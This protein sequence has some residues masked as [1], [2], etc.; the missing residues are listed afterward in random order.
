[1]SSLA[2]IRLTPEQQ[3]AVNLRG[4]S[5]LV[6][7]AAG[8]GKTRV[9]VERL[10]AYVTDPDNP[11]DI[12]TFL[13][14]TYTRAA[15][16]ELHSRILS[17]LRKRSAAQPE[18]RRL[19]RQTDLCHRA[20]IGTIH[21]FC[22]TVLRENCHLLGLAPDFTVA[23]E[24]RSESIRH[25]ALERL[26]EQRYE[27]IDTDAGFRA[28]VDT[29]GAGRS[30]DRLIQVVDDLYQKLQSHPYP[31]EWANAQIQ[32]MDV[33]ACSD[34]AETIWGRTLLEELRRDIAYWAELYDRL[35]AE[36]YGDPDNEKIVAAY[37]E[38]L[39]EDAEQLR[40]IC[41]AAEQG[42]ELTRTQFPFS[43]GKLKALRN[44]PNPALSD[45]I[46]ACR[47]TLKSRAE[48]WAAYFDGTSEE[49]L[50]DLTAT[51]PAMEALLRLTLDLTDAFSKE[52]RR[53]NI[54]DFS[55]LEHFAIQ[56]LVHQEDRSPT[57]LAQHI[58]QRYTEIMID[59]FQDV[60]EVQDLLFRAVSRNE[61]NLFMVGDVKQSIYRFRLAD[62][63]IFIRKYNTY[64][65]YAEAEGSAPRRILLRENFR[66]QPTVLDSTNLVFDNIMSTELGDI[67]YDDNARLRCGTTLLRE[68][69]APTMLYLLPSPAS[70]DSDSP[71][72][73]RQEADFIA[74]QIQAMLANG[75]TVLDKD[76][77][78]R[79]MTYGDIVILMRSPGSY[80][81]I[82]H[83]AL[84]A[85]G[86]PVS[87]D[88]SG[89]FFTAPEISTML[90]LLSIVD[91]PHQDVPLTS[92]LRSPIFGF[93]PDELSQI[94]TCNR[95]SDF[96]TALREAAATMPK[97]QAFLET[98]QGFRDRAADLPVDQMIWHIYTETHLMALCSAMPD[99]ALRRQKLMILFRY[100]GQFESGGS[101]GLFL[102]LAWINR[103]IER[104]EEPRLETDGVEN[105][106]SILSIHK[107]KGLEFPVVFLADTAHR[108]NKSDATAPVL[109]HSRLGLGPRY[110]D[111]E[112]HVEYPTTA[113]RAI[114]RSILRENMSEEM[115][116][117]YVAMTRAR[118]R[119]ILTASLPNPEKKWDELQTEAASPI[120]PQVLFN[121]NSFADWLMRVAVLDKEEALIQTHFVE[122][123][124][125]R[126]TTAGAVTAAAEEPAESAESTQSA[127][128]EEIRRRLTYVYPHRAAI[129]L[130]SKLTATEAE[131]L[132]EDQLDPADGSTLEPVPTRRL[133]FREPNFMPKQQ[134]GLSGPEIGIAVHLVL[135][136][137]D[138]A[139]TGSIDAVRSEVE[140]LQ[141]KNILRPEQA[142][143]IRPAQIYRFFSSET[144]QR[145][146]RA[147]RIVREF[148]FSLLAPAEQYFAGGMGE[149]VLL[150]GVIDCFFEE[151]GALT[152][153]DYKTDY[154][155]DET[156]ESAVQSY[157]PQLRAY[158]DALQRITGQPVSGAVL[159]FLGAE[160]AIPL[161][162]DETKTNFREC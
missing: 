139:K 121:S 71:G 79:P 49:L 58:S 80:G 48:E 131:D 50:A 128:L 114:N 27:Q 32:A 96:Y 43:F 134:R 116:V 57:E 99:G 15:A 72:K 111:P 16:A 45:R 23:D 152:I 68:T 46:K 102:F 69:P 39:A 143:A 120:P 5:L 136:H 142:D 150:Q 157:L 109:V 64:Q 159:Y 158:R 37:G 125:G 19:R 6:S 129:D 92:V 3:A 148:R 101:R 124:T 13:I 144:G 11:K 138:F 70:T 53:Q 67:D 56:L 22:T 127:L 130:P 42:W 126:L 55:D 98:L 78:T 7:A 41:R 151:A 86:I 21:S 9:L 31:D 108:F 141:Q 17:D 47:K 146:L 104:G 61:T 85:A 133:I 105:A 40:A 77:N 25:R 115:R 135:Q 44:S 73:T 34:I 147:K 33:S 60:N 107:S 66:S 8:S 153:V 54:V 149:D 52:K 132:P 95:G 65:D 1:M 83:A 29:V 81:S 93:T 113:R 155:T 76:G 97:C 112:R 20:Q 90:S 156:L 35:L 84:S 162:F 26:L 161:T 145:L 137:I 4:S 87:S 122:P 110:T 18:N 117:L 59:E 12:D 62:P 123:G 94:R 103:L 106:V 24:E 89:G 28:L 63:Q 140:R 119:L 2:D 118:E 88:N 75:E 30:D 82:Y 14:I 51:A 38:T 91:N 74:A 160:L 10:M 100:A 36:L 154:V